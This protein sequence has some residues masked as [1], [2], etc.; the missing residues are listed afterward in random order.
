MNQG[1][2]RVSVRSDIDVLV[3]DGLRDADMLE[4]T[5]ANL[6]PELALAMG[7]AMS[8][9]YAFT[10]TVEGIPAA[11]FGVCPDARYPDAEAG[12]VWLLGTDRILKIR[13]QF[14]RESLDWIDEIASQYSVLG[15]SV[16]CAN[17]V[18][19]RWLKWLGF[20]F[21]KANGPMVEFARISSHV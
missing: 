21:I 4:L 7:L 5:E 2:T 17:L 18:H 15:N 20:T 1:A 3:R 12:V 9:P 8:Q 19:I 13:R 10:V 11:M 16:H 14:L 6:E